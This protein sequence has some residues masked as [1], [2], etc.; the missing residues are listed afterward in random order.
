MATIVASSSSA[1]VRAL[2]SVHACASSSTKGTLQCSFTSGRQLNLKLSASK[3]LK[4]KLRTRISASAEDLTDATT[5]RTGG[6]VE[7]LPSG[8]WPESFSMLNYE[9][10]SAHYEPVLFKEGAQPNTILADV[11]S[12]QIWAASPTDTLETVNHHFE[13]VS[14]LPVIDKDL[15][16]LGVIS[17]KDRNKS[18]QGLSANIGE[19]MSTPAITISADKTVQDAAVLMLKNKVHRIPVVNQT[20]QLVGMVTRTDIFKALETEE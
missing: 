4:T 6:D 15:K 5:T 20:G 1:C 9:D 17:K 11:M 14:G 13:E 18:A 16:V 3:N 7:Y 8:E 12:K 2:N 19:V 10:L